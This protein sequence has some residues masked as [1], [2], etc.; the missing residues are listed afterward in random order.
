MQL[1]SFS[2]LICI[3]ALFFLPNLIAQQPQDPES[4]AMDELMSEIQEEPLSA[5]NMDQFTFIETL[6][7]RMTLEEKIGQLTLYT[8]DWGEKGPFLRDQY[9]GYLKQGKVGALFNAV[10]PDFIYQLQKIAVEETRL[11]IPLIFGFDVIHGFRTI[12]PIPLAEASSWNLDL[13]EQ[14]ARVAAQ[15]ASAVGIHW[16]FAPMVDIA[17]DPRWGRIAEGSGED[18]YLGSVIAQARVRGFQGTDLSAK[19]TIIACAKHYAAYGAAEA[20]RD[21][22]IVDMSEQRLREVYLPPFHASVQAGVKTFMTSF[23]DINGVPSTASRWLLT[24]ILRR[25]WR[26]DGFIVTDYTSI[27][28]LIPHGVAANPA[29]AGKLAISAGVDMDMEAGIFQNEL[30][31]LVEKKIVSEAMIDDAVRRILAIKWQLGLFKNPYHYCD[32]EHAM[33]KLLTPEHRSVARK[34]AQESIVL[35][36]NTDQILPLDKKIK[37]L[38]VIGPLAANQSELLGCWWGAGDTKDA[39]PILT[40]IQAAVSPETKIL[41]AQGCAIQDA[42]TQGFAEAVS[43]ANQADAVVA[44]LGEAAWM[45][46]EAASRASL[47]LPGVQEQLLQELH[48]TGKPIILVLLNGRPLTIAWAEA[49]VAAI[50]ECWFLGTETGPAVASVLFGDYNPSA[51]LPITF[52][53][54]VGQIPIYYSYKSTGRPMDPSNKYTSKYFDIPNTPL[55]PFGYGLGFTTFQLSKPQLSQTKITDQEN[56]TVQVT[57]TNTGKRAGTETVQLYIRDEVASITRPM[58]ELR[59]FRKITLDPGSSAEITFTLTP[60]DFYFYNRDCQYVLEPG[61]FQI[62]VGCNSSDVM[63]ERLEIVKK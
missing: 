28:E 31:K 48:K 55:Y 63:T 20:G 18:T 56:C 8:A 59:S 4:K 36:K 51:K 44:V 58:K 40:G 21:Y 26:F 3:L 29:E 1:F 45:S 41:Y 50:L 38:A 7:S 17:R 61:I 54:T 10:T 52:P 39:I 27:Q 24:D 33:S 23:N 2:S 62:M 34:M 12:F 14:G 25:E 6:L 11:K 49:N 35:L 46:G 37:T 15:E 16:T 13:I 32:P 5:E 53:R 22:N 57:L 9:L 30:T 42:N 60:K 43:I 19:D 47:D